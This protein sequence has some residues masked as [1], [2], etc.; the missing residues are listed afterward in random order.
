MKTTLTILS[1]L[2]LFSCAT[3][4]RITGSWKN[5]EI[6]S[7]T[8]HHVYVAALTSN[9]IAR[10]VAETEVAAALEKHGVRVTKSMSQFPP[11]NL[12]D[13]L[14]L[15]KVMDSVHRY[16]ADAILTLTLI[17]KK[18][19]MRY[20]PGS[21]NYYPVA[22]YNFYGRFSGYYNYWYPYMYDPGYYVED[23]IYFIESNLYDV[24]TDE[25]IWSAQSKTYNPSGFHPFSKEF[26]ETLAKQLQKDGL[27]PQQNGVMPAKK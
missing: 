2:V 9:T 14:S 21:Y 23:E 1:A 17:R 19:E 20:V 15:Q 25:L 13:T 24:K 6:G 22:R 5:P 27:V 12:K 18:S 8:I 11:G 4:T 16:D 3:P 10:S 26:A 7:R